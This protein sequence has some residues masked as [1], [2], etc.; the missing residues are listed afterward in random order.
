MTKTNVSFGKAIIYRLINEAI[1]N[2]KRIDDFERTLTPF[3][4]NIYSLTGNCRFSYVTIILLNPCLKRYT[5]LNWMDEELGVQ[6][7]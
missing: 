7:S 4:S 1:L 2:R 6:F 3:G 5:L